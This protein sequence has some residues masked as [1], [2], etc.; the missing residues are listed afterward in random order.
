MNAAKREQTMDHTTLDRLVSMAPAVEGDDFK[1]KDEELGSVCKITA[2]EDAAVRVSMLDLD[3]SGSSF[4]SEHTAWTNSSTT[5]TLNDDS[6]TSFVLEECKRMVAFPRGRSRLATTSPLGPSKKPSIKAACSSLDDSNV[7]LPTL[8]TATEDFSS[9]HESTTSFGLED[10]KHSI[11]HTPPKTRRILVVRRGSLIPTTPTTPRLT[12]SIIDLGSDL[13]LPPNSA[14]QEDCKESVVLSPSSSSLRRSSAPSLSPRGVSTRLVNS[15]SGIMNLPS[16]PT[17]DRV[18]SRGSSQM[19]RESKDSVTYPRTRRA[20]A[21]CLQRLENTASRRRSDTR[22]LARKSFK[23]RAVHSRPEAVQQRGLRSKRSRSWTHQER[24]SSQATMVT[25]PSTRNTKAGL[26]RHTSWNVFLLGA[27]DSLDNDHDAQSKVQQRSSHH[28]KS[29][30]D[31][32]AKRSQ[33]SSWSSSPSARRNTMPVVPVPTKRGLRRATHGPSS[34]IPGAYA[35]GERPVFLAMARPQ[36]RSED[37]TEDEFHVMIDNDAEDE[38]ELT[39]ADFHGDDYDEEESIHFYPERPR[40]ERRPPPTTTTKPE[41]AV[42]N[43]EEQNRR[44]KRLAYS[45][46]VLLGLISFFAFGAIIIKPS[47]LYDEITELEDSSN[48]RH[49][50][51]FHS[52]EHATMVL[53]ESLPLATKQ[54]IQNDDGSPQSRAFDWI[55]NDPNLL[56]FPLW[57]MRQRFALAAIFHSLQGSSWPLDL[58]KRWLSYK[59]DECSWGSTAASPCNLDGTYVRLSLD[60]IPSLGRGLPGEVTLLTSLQELSITHTTQN[61]SLE[62]LLPE[63]LNELPTLEI[64]NL[65]NNNLAG[66]TIPRF[67]GSFP[68]LKE[69]YLAEASLVGSIPNELSQLARLETLDLSQNFLTGTMMQNAAAMTNMGALW[70]H[71]NSLS[72]PL[73]PSWSSLDKLHSLFLYSNT[74]TG[75]LP[76]EW[77]ALTGLKELRLS[78]NLLHGTIPNEWG[79]MSSLNSFAVDG[80]EELGGS[81]P[82]LICSHSQVN[83]MHFSVDCKQIQCC[84]YAPE[85]YKNAEHHQ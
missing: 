7:T 64:I 68:N 70:L 56:S 46:V 41:E 10:S 29:W 1:G 67:L 52:R 78:H 13:A 34:L 62:L 77:G 37:E 40:A 74:L 83:R 11:V 38:W 15:S 66:S 18:H 33:R 44:S 16:L 8:S 42:K 48:P 80:N 5:Q 6:Q 22:G 84:I 21:P 79:T 59:D 73:P 76:P 65:S 28:H 30:A 19:L 25:T 81:I 24:R 36:S 50:P 72:G 9:N 12:T 51:T 23:N 55:S 31:K 47:F 54:K 57:L 71:E 82:N 43:E 26:R 45:L 85:K 53:L 4:P 63:R 58:Q 2:D 27:R 3:A 39:T 35:C 32:E 75:T 49:G 60:R 14:I 20:S 17:L 61:A 69:L